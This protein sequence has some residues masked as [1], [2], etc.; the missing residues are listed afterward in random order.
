M[1]SKVGAENGARVAHGVTLPNVCCERG[2]RSARNPVTAFR[3]HSG[4]VAGD[5]KS[6]KS[7]K[8]YARQDSNL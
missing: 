7:R 2:K 4:N 1:R 6:G 3:L 8:N 5:P